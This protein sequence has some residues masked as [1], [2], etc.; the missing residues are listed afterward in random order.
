MVIYKTTNLLN[1]KFYIGQDSKNKKS[2]FGSGKLLNCAIKKYGKENFKKEI[3][4]ECFTKEDLDK[5]EIYWIDLLNSTN[6]EI[7]YNIHEGGTGGD[8]YKGK[9][10]EEME[11]I[12]SKISK[13]VKLSY[14]T[15]KRDITGFATETAKKISKLGI[16]KHKLDNYESFKIKQN[17]TK[18]KNG[19]HPGL[20]EN[21]NSNRERTQKYYSNQEN[22]NKQ[23][24]LMKGKIK[25]I[26]KIDFYI[27][28]YG[29]LE[30]EL[31]YND[32]ILKLK[33]RQSNKII[34]EEIKDKISK[35]LKIRYSKQDSHL[36]GIKLEEK[37]GKE[38][39]KE[40]K[41]LLSINSKGKSVTKET[42]DKRMNT[43]KIKYP[44]GFKMS[45]ESKD[46]ISLK[47][48]GRKMSYDYTENINKG[49]NTKFNKIEP[50]KMLNIKT[51]KI[52]YFKNKKQL[53]L[54]FYKNIYL[55]KG[56]RNCSDKI[57]QVL[58]GNKNNYLNYDFKYADNK[59]KEEDF[60]NVQRE[61]I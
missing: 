18:L 4:E 35:T 21:K 59:I 25:G 39:A 53:I 17:E 43:K 31:K 58:I 26:K 3:L 47:N 29:K 44:N 10:A 60:V 55:G 42:V 51:E 37:V 46:K 54:Y 56:Y 15:G 5:K 49:L 14:S 23:S 7:G 61:S 27:K 30:G 19:T 38:R 2:Y 13:G 20:T 36:K 50:I 41:M 8:N 32:F 40:I 24:L 48:K 22:R 12:K 34:S 1:G 9:S 33:E 28:K 11:I 52:L 45:Q 6:K 57:Y 16:A